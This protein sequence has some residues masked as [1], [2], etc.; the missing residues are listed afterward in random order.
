M[1]GAGSNSV[2]RVKRSR[3]ERTTGRLRD[4]SREDAH[5]PDSLTDVPPS[6]FHGPSN[7]AIPVRMFDTDPGE[8]R[9]IAALSDVQSQRQYRDTRVVIGF[10]EKMRRP[11]ARDE[12]GGS[13]NPL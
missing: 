9:I 5:E 10:V 2:D 12:G 8:Q 7:T 13:R 3:A 1:V 11:L 4:W 6:L